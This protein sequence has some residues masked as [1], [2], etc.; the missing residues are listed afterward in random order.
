M[1]I[2][3]LTSYRRKGINAYLE[4]VCGG[5]DI[6]D[7]EFLVTKDYGRP[8]TP[9]DVSKAAQSKSHT[10]S[11][12]LSNKP[13]GVYKFKEACGHKTRHGW[14]RVEDGQIVSEFESEAES[15]KSE[16]SILLPELEGSEK[17]VAWAKKIRWSF[18][19]STGEAIS[20]WSRNSAAYEC[21]E[22]A[23]LAKSW[24]DSRD[25]LN[26]QKFIDQVKM[27]EAKRA[28]A[29]AEAILYEAIAGEIADTRIVVDDETC[30]EAEI[31]AIVYSD[32]I[33]VTSSV[34]GAG[35]KIPSDRK[36]VG[37]KG[38]MRWVYSL[39][40][41]PEILKCRAIEFCLDE[42]GKKIEM[43]NGVKVGL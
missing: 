6:M 34:T 12:N 13:D 14:I 38:D 2:L 40:R 23:P 7:N 33:E 10:V 26:P 8:S 32:R 31:F 27:L 9:E 36:Y 15:L 18:I 30:I 11:I 35:E 24:I 17:Q 25:K 43:L 37:S 21:L 5:S 3:Q 16:Q 1:A 42:S 4:M 28:K 22:S 39:D 29:A 19:I 20:D 41:L